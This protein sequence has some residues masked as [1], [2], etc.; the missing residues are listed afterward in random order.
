MKLT[1]TGVEWKS[2]AEEQAAFDALK[3]AITTKCVGYFNKEWKSILTVDASPV[4]L[5]AV[6]LQ[7]NPKDPTQ[8]HMVCCVSRM[9]TDV[10]RRYS[11][12]EKEALGVVWGFE[13]L[14]MYLL[15]RKFTIETDNRA[16]KL[17][18]ANT[19][20]RPPARIERLALRL[21]QFDYEIVHK[22]GD[23]NAAD[24]FSRHPVKNNE[25]RLPRRSQS[26]CRGR[27][28]Y[29]L[30]GHDEASSISNDRRS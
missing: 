3:Q 21:S 10:E 24:Y 8:R 26:Q 28:L 6:L 1:K 27:V 19:R 11:Q 15:G 14:W 30:F 2:G 9:L 16:I 17:I 7:Y 5:G 29:K 4:S 13:R 20:S 18:L 25:R 12:C 23:S 22:P